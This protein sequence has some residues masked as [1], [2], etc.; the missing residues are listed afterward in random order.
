MK[1]GNVWFK[2]MPGNMF[3]EETEDPVPYIYEVEPLNA[4]P[5]RCYMCPRGRGN[6]KRPVGF[7]PLSI[8]ERIIK[9]I[10]GHQRMLRLHHFGEP[11]LHPE[12]PLFIRLTRSAG[13]IPA[14]SLNPSSLDKTLIDRMVDSGVGIVCFSLDSLN[15]ERLKKIRGIN[16][17]IQYCLEMI[18]YFIKKSRLSSQPVFKII[19]M[20]SLEINRDE[21][22]AFLSLKERYPEDDVYV[23]ISGNYGFGDIELIRETDHEAVKGI[24]SSPAV[25]TA[26]FDDVVILWN[27]DV[28]LCC[29]DY[30]G[31]NVIGNIADTSLIEIWRADRVQEIRKLFCTGQTQSLR[32]CNNCYLAPHK[33]PSANGGRLRRGISEE[34]YLLGL[35]PPLLNDL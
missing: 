3:I 19:Q 21:Q 25:C 5:Y 18:D 22:V 1:R 27:G 31:F 20:V 24:L 12:L 9:E 32:L 26:P 30:D 16:K 35:Y 34:E 33:H 10:P 13:L 4:C 17:P 2:G 29:Y 7:M 14:L 8:F 6:M 23:Y 15:S 11:V 28:V